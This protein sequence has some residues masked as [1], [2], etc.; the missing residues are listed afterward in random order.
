MSSRAPSD[1]DRKLAAF[2]KA[3]MTRR[4]LSYSEFGSLLGVSKSTCQRLVACESSATL[5]L[6]SQIR[7]VLKVSVTDIFRGS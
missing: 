1:L 5:Q 3:E 6:L 2:L 7:R 4:E